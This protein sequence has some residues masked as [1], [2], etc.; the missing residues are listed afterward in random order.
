MQFSE[1]ETIIKSGEDSKHQF[2]ENFTNAIKKIG[3]CCNL[4]QINILHRMTIV[5]IRQHLL[6][7]FT[8]LETKM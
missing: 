3:I 5:M 6:Q 8:F 7:I 2:K 1:L 4:S